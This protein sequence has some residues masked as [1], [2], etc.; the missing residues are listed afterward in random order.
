MFL[1]VLVI[2]YDSQH[3]HK[4]IFYTLDIFSML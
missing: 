4:H 1:P 2:E 3:V